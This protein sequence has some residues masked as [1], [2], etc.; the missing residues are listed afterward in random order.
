MWAKIK[1]WGSA[2][3]V[4]VSSVFEGCS[5]GPDFKESRNQLN[6]TEPGLSQRGP[7]PAPCQL[8]IWFDFWDLELT[9]WPAAAPRS[10]SSQLP[11]PWT[12]PEGK[13]GNEGG[14]GEK[15]ESQKVCV[16]RSFHLYVGG[17]A[18]L[19]SLILHDAQTTNQRHDFPAKNERNI[20]WSCKHLSAGIN[21]GCS[22]KSSP[23][24]PLSCQIHFYKPR[25]SQEDFY[26]S[27]SWLAGEC[28]RCSTWLLNKSWLQTGVLVMKAGREAAAEARSR[29][30]FNQR[31][32]LHPALVVLGSDLHHGSVLSLDKVLVMKMSFHRW[33]ITRMASCSCRNK[34]LLFPRK[35]HWWIQNLFHY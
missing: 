21:P 4:S 3:C 29:Y 28:H 26:S 2:A 25:P 1:G 13:V 19:I 11:S 16:L 17:W 32:F 24:A 30:S 14:V 5:S 18:G 15:T 6:Q 10:S 35:N 12:G 20:S 7:R 22:P 27:C 8:S 34:S 33:K 9:V 23:E 31:R